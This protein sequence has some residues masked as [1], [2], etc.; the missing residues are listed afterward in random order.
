MQELSSSMTFVIYG[1]FDTYYNL[2][3]L[4]AKFHSSLYFWKY[5]RILILFSWVWNSIFFLKIW[6]CFYETG[7]TFRK[8]M[9]FSH[10]CSI[11]FNYIFLFFE[12]YLSI[13]LKKIRKKVKKRKKISKCCNSYTFNS[14]LVFLKVFVDWIFCCK[15]NVYAKIYIVFQRSWN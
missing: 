6:T 9:H 15:L 8:F 14:K 7:S 13:I 11:K 5:L 1:V 4:S 12:C 2:S 3:T 10:C